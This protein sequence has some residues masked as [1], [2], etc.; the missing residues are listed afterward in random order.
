MEDHPSA[1]NS[2]P[3]SPDSLLRSKDY[4]VLLVLAAVIGV[5]VSLA[6]WGYLELIHYL[7]QWLY[8][9][10]PSGLS[11]S[12]V[13]T[14]WP[15]PVLAVASVPIAFALARMPGSGGHKPAEGLKAG[16]PTQPIELPGVLLASLASIGFGMVLGP[17]A[18]LIAIAGGLG[19]LAV[20][21]ARKDAPDQVLAL[22]AGA[23]SFA[24]MSSLFGSPIVGAVIIIEAAGLG[25][26]ILPVILLPGLLAAGIG[27]LVFIGMGSLTGLS[28]SAY[29]IAPLALPPYHAPTISAFGWTIVLAAAVAVGV[30]VIARIG[31]V[32]N[33]ATSRRPFVIVPLAALAVGVLAIA[34]GHFSGKPED[35]VLFSGQDTM[36]A[37]VNQ[38]ASF[39]QSAFALFLIFKGLAYGVSLGSARGGPTFPAMFLGIVAGLLCAHLPGFSERPAVAALMGAGTVSILRLPLASI[40]IALVVSQAGASTTPLIIVAVVVAYL[41][42]LALSA[43]RLSEQPR[44]PLADAP[45]DDGHGAT[46]RVSTDELHS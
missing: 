34:F 31:L 44:P 15:L 11:L 20:R 36:G 42:V 41:V 6:S 19:I 17:E 4:R 37:V 33:A 39:S 10:L 21:S 43:A 8:K 13:P 40:I 28:S 7:Q 30:F 3:P 45:S 24:A 1:D 9:D 2:S 22:I 38:A 12:P 27:S 26:A 18:P 23:A 29:A 25:G 32:V 5:V 16:P 35:L 46:P 14:W